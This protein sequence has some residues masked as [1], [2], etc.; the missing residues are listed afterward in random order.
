MRYTHNTIPVRL[1]HSTRNRPSVTDEMYRTVRACGTHRQAYRKL[2]Q[3]LHYAGYSNKDIKRLLKPRQDDINMKY[4]LDRI[5]GGE[6][7]QYT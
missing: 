3:L 1:Q 4:K 5:E 6:Y 2:R 7:A